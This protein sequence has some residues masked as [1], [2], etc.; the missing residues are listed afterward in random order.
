MRLNRRQLVKS[1]SICAAG[2]ATGL[3]TLLTAKRGAAQQKKPKFLIV[4]AGAGGGS[5]ID[6]FLAIRQ[7]EAGPAA[8]GIN[9]FPDSEVKSIAGTTIRAV[10]LSR[11]SVGAIPIPFAANQSGFVTKHKD[12]LMVVTQTGTSVNHTIAQKRALTGNEAWSGRTL[13]EAVAAE[14]GSGFPL[15][16]VNMAVDGY[17]QHGT[18][19]TLAQ[20]ALNEPVANAALWPL[21]LDGAKGI[22]GLPSRERLDIARRLRDEKLDAE[23]TF[24][25]TFKASE[26]LELWK[27]QKLSQQ[28]L[29]TLDL[30]SKLN[31][32]P[33]LPPQ[34]PLEE[35]GLSESPDGQRVRQAFPNFATDPLEA[36]AALT[37]LLIKNRVSV[38]VTISP[39]FNVLLDTSRFRL[40]NPP[41]AFDFSHNAHRATQAVMWSRMLG[42]ADKLID[43][44]KGE[45]LEP[46]S[47]ESY[48]DHSMI[49][50][51]TEF[52]RSK[53]RPDNADVFGTSHDLNNGFAIV[54]PLA[55][56]NK[57]LGGVDPT[58]GL[59]YGYDP[60][61]PAGVPRPGTVMEEKYVYAGVLHALGVD[62]SGSG[63][64][65]V[66]A[67]RKNA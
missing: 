18:D 26:R 40:V 4:F 46:G 67:L 7:S 30:I 52:G 39:S 19:R 56:G 33:N 11:T 49:Y 14:Y 66:R 27:Q 23:S 34:I 54:S 10:D 36:Q 60:E 47:G 65:D 63:L 13:Q 50:F 24:Y 5:I 2:G 38:A 62:T 29:E 37:F 32:Y 28:Q 45:E 20:W 58:T 16:N 9:C 43:L 21:S 8:A 55:N 12:D 22:K 15:P 1:L 41:L 53:R 44:L 64:P 25:R 51:A 61:D 6:S 59:T 48:W 17:V 35:Y 57:V 42:L 31:V 3:A